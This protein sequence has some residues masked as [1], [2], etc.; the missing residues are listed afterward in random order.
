MLLQVQNKNKLKSL[1]LISKKSPYYKSIS[2]RKQMTQFWTV[3]QT[4]KSFPAFNSKTDKLNISVWDRTKTKK[5]CICH[6]FH[7][8]WQAN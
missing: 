8:N 6:Q 2:L 4:L 1:M 7:H 5:K 3:W